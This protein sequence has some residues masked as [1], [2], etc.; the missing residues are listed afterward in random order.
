MMLHIP[1]VLPKKWFLSRSW[2]QFL[3][4]NYCNAPEV[5]RI[6]TIKNARNGVGERG[7]GGE[8]GVAGKPLENVSFKHVP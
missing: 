6:K 5:N 1:Q 7:G 3:Y 8:G 4:Q 2:L